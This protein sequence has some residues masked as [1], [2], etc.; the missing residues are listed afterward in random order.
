MPESH[1]CS[2]RQTRST[3]SPITHSVVSPASFLKFA[4]SPSP[5]SH[6]LMSSLVFRPPFLR[7]MRRRMKPSCTNPIWSINSSWMPFSM[8]RVPA[9]GLNG[10]PAPS[11]D[12]IGLF[13]YWRPCGSWAARY[14]KAH[15]LLS[16]QHQ[17]WHL[18]VSW[19]AISGWPSQRQKY[20][21]CTHCRLLRIDSIENR[22]LRSWAPSLHIGSRVYQYDRFVLTFDN[23][24]FLIFSREE[25]RFILCSTSVQNFVSPNQ[26]WTRVRFF[27]D[28]FSD[29]ES[30]IMLI[31]QRRTPCQKCPRCLHHTCN[32]Q[33]IVIIVDLIFH[34][35]VWISFTFK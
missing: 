33:F 35:I 7:F 18:D 21:W 19:L 20:N 14:Y 3:Y 5:P 25:E 8:S 26:I 6:V 22:Y 27:S 16:P 11:G 13:F 2:D 4:I 15:E 31:E 17:N 1:I 30:L 34:D 32:L 24:P 10:L 29:S 12:C 23:T 9:I 28:I